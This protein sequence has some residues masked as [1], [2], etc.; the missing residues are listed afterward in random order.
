[1]SLSSCDKPLCSTYNFDETWLGYL[2]II[3]QILVLVGAVNWGFTAVRQYFNHEQVKDLLGW[4]PTNKNWW[5]FQ[6]LIYM[7]VFLSAIGLILI[8]TLATSRDCVCDD[9]KTS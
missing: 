6:N 1:M 7:L 9:S 8:E 3:L 4:L 2:K 5:I